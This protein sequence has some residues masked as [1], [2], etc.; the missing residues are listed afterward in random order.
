MTEDTEDTEDIGAGETAEDTEKTL[1]LH[2]STVFRVLKTPLYETQHL[3]EA[4]KMMQSVGAKCYKNTVRAGR[5]KHSLVNISFLPP[6]RIPLTTLLPLLPPDQTALFDVKIKDS[7][8]VSVIH[9]NG[10]LYK[11][12]DTL[13]SLNAT[14][15]SRPRSFRTRKEDK[16]VLSDD[17]ILPMD[18]VSAR[19]PLITKLVDN[20]IKAEPNARTVLIKYLRGTKSDIPAA[21]FS[22]SPEELQERTL[23]YNEFIRR[24]T[25]LVAP[26]PESATSDI[27]L[28]YTD[29]NSQCKVYCESPQPFFLRLSYTVMMSTTISVIL[30]FTMIS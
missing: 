7:A 1:L 2:P 14:N 28:V 19:G 6:C 27:S 9:Q 17:T 20:S 11:T 3:S 22:C 12:T 24:T 15:L 4:Q 13:I 23:S 16:F 29:M 5:R 30:I 26:P 10:M 25:R 18:V 21:T 8:P